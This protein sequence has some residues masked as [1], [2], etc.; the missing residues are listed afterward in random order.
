MS[1]CILTTNVPF[2]VLVRFL[3]AHLCEDLL[4]ILYFWFANYHPG[5]EPSRGLPLE[6]T[7]MR[8]DVTMIPAMRQGRA[9]LRNAARVQARL[10]GCS[11]W[12]G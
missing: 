11:G 9:T 7:L 5:A 4:R 2:P 8:L 1:Q 12:F 6:D 10:R 3:K